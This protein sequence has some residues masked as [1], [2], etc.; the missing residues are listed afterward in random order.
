[1][2]NPKDVLNQITL[3]DLVEE[4][5]H[6]QLEAQL[7]SLQR[8]LYAGD[9]GWV[10]SEL[11]SRYASSLWA[12]GECELFGVSIPRFQGRVYLTPELDSFVDVRRL[13]TL[14]ENAGHWLS[15]GDYQDSKVAQLGQILEGSSPIAGGLIRSPGR[16]GEYHLLEVNVG[17]A[18]GEQPAWGI[19]FLKHMQLG[20]GMCSQIC[21][22]MASILMSKHAT[23]IDSVADITLR[24]RGFYAPGKK[25]ELAIGGL[26]DTEM[27]ASLP[28]GLT[29]W[30]ES[31]ALK[32]PVDYQI[33]CPGAHGQL[34]TR[35][36]AYT[37]SNVPVILLVDLG[38]MAGLKITH[39]D[40]SVF[41]TQGKLFPVDFQNRIQKAHANDVKEGNGLRQRRHAVLLGGCQLAKP[42]NAQAS[43]GAKFIIHDPATYPHLICTA[44]QLFDARTQEE[45]KQSDAKEASEVFDTPR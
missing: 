15:R 1:M 43:A 34:V 31:C 13:A 42:T 24:A 23:R 8:W 25:G 36:R 22:L 4:S 38:K 26:D 41:S 30:T 18:F 3:S 9:Q 6:A 11:I 14:K 2:L 45:R 39:P 37:L 17:E 20:G 19:P 5:G 12:R 28:E 16:L 10:P 44:E 40:Q 35:L 33:W 7:R 27:V 32:E 29:G 21:L